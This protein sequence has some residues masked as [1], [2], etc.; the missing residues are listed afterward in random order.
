[1]LSE[2]K[3][4]KSEGYKLVLLSGGFYPYVSLVGKKLDFDYIFATELKYLDKGFDLENELKFITGENK[5][6]IILKEFPK[7]TNVDWE[8]SYAYADNY[9]DS[10][11]LELTGN[12][13]AVN[14]DTRLTKHA[15]D[16][17]WAI[18]K[19]Y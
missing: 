14:P 4:L 2:I 3:R 11:V 10:D 15:K 18:I 5:K 19:H 8:A 7:E 13:H 16:K 6:E 12:P 9:F 1:M 17:G